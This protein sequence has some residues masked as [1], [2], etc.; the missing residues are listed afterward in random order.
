MISQFVA[1]MC[2]GAA[3]MAFVAA[4][5]FV[6]LHSKLV[7]RL[8]TDGDGVKIVGSGDRRYAVVDIT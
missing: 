3:M 7:E 8:S 2:F 4:G 5:V 1:G 6:A